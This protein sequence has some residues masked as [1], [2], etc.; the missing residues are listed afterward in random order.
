MKKIICVIDMLEGFCNEGALAS[1]I[2]KK[3]IPNIEKVLKDNKK[4]DNLFIC[5]SHNTFDLEMKQYP[6]HCLKDTKEAEIVKELKPYVKSVLEKNSTNAFHLFDKKL[7]EKYD[8]F[9]L[10]GCCTDICVLQ[11]ALSLKTYLNENRIDKKV[12]VLK[13]AVA[14]F[15][16]PGHNA[17]QFHNF[18]LN[19]MANA[20]IEIQ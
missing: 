5:D 4:E 14:T 7:I 11:F 17:Q 3:I 19:L 2:V 13:D 8:Q 10:T 15:D 9:V 20:G 18:T 16:A 6:L 12:I 1:P